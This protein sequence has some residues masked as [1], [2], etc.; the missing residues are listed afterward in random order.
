MAWW[1]RG[2]VWAWQRK[3]EEDLGQIVGL[4]VLNDNV[5]P[6]FVAFPPSK[7]AISPLRQL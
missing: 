5:G 3:G 2:I 4:D 6:I 1:V 7:F